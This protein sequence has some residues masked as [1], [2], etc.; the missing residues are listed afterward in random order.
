[1][2]KIHGRLDLELTVLGIKPFCFIDKHVHPRQYQDAVGLHKVHSV[3]HRGRGTVTVCLVE[4]KHLQL[5]YDEIM[6]NVH[7]CIKVRRR[8]LRKLFGHHKLE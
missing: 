7:E 4:N 3:V 5:T 2:S 6:N 1:M 8:A